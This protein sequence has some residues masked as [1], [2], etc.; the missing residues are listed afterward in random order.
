MLNK[1]ANGT[2]KKPS[3]STKMNQGIYGMNANK[4]SINK[5]RSYIHGSEL[6][7]TVK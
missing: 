3:K 2:I 6:T 7:G 4:S 1:K 5:E